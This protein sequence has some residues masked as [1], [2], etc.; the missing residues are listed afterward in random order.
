MP[1]CAFLVAQ[2]LEISND[3][4]HNFP[5]PLCAF[6]VAEKTIVPCGG[7]LNQLRPPFSYVSLSIPCG[8]N[9]WYGKTENKNWISVLTTVICT[10]PET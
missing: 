10:H 4:G 7:K 3:T 2:N 8:S 1:L 6:L 5:M 9:L